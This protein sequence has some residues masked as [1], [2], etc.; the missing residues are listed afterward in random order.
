MYTKASDFMKLSKHSILNP[1]AKGFIDGLEAQDQ[2]DARGKVEDK[3]TSWHRTQFEELKQK[4]PIEF[5]RYRAKKLRSK[6]LVAE[7]TK[8]T[9][10]L[11]PELLRYDQLAREIIRYKE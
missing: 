1:S 9:S 7:K 10:R 6:S 2:I 8:D 4:R 5:L 11:Y 3:Q